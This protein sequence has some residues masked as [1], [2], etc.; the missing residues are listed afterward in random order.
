MFHLM[1]FGEPIESRR[2]KKNKQKYWNLKGRTK[3]NCNWM[4]ITV[5]SRIDESEIVDTLNGDIE[6][7]VVVV[8]VDASYEL[9]RAANDY[10]FIY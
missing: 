3:E 5:R 6:V 1:L 2:K 9:N 7:I 10:V 8:V 4:K